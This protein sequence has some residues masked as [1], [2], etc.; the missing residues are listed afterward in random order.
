MRRRTVSPRQDELKEERMRPSRFLGYDRN[1]LGMYALQREMFEVAESQFRRAVYLNPYEPKF[2]QHL[3]WCLYKQGKYAE[4]KRCIV[5]VIGR[6][7][8]DEESMHI[9]LKIE[10]KMEMDQKSASKSERDSGR[11]KT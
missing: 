2:L 6:R 9:L 1:S 8:G 10:E 5:E 7:P 4:A 11:E 3:A